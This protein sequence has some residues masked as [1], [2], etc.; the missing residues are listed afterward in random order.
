MYNGIHSYLTWLPVHTEMELVVSHEQIHL[1]LTASTVRFPA[2]QVSLQV[3]HTGV[4]QIPDNRYI[5][6][7]Y[8]RLLT[9]STQIP[10]I[11]KGFL[12]ILC[13]FSCVI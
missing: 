10:V 6:Q 11:N 1:S 7:V 5:T 2:L 9:L 12:L 13:K 4:P 8:V 3:H